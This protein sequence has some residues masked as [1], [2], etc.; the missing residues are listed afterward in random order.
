MVTRKEDYDVVYD[1]M[2]TLPILEGIVSKSTLLY[3]DGRVCVHCH[4]D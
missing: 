4:S 1:P 2:Q 3:G